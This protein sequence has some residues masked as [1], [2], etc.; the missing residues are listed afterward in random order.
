MAITTA[1]QLIEA[2]RNAT[3]GATIFLERGNY[4]V[5]VPLFVPDDVTLQGAGVMQVVDGLPVGFQAGTESTIKAGPGLRGNLVTLG[6]HSSLRRL[7]LHGASEALFEDDEGRG[8]NTVAVPSRGQHDMVSA[9][10]EE[11]ELINEIT[12]PSGPDGPAG[13][14]ILAYTRNPKRGAAPL[15]HVHAR[16]TLALTRSIVSPAPD[17]GKA[18]F[19]MNFASHGQVTINLTTNEIGGPL[20]VVGGMARP[21]AVD[22]A[23]TTVTSNGNHYS[24][25]G[26]DTGWQITGGSTPPL[27][28]SANADSNTANVNSTDDQIENFQNGIVAVGGRRLDLNHGTCARNT[29]NLSLTRMKPPTIPPSLDGADFQFVGALSLGSFP[30][31]DKNAVVVDVLAGTAPDPLVHIDVHGAGFGTGNQLVFKGTLAALQNLDFG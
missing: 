15:P 16:V 10:I 26:S 12:T 23:T 5:G 2:V 4:T 21:D 29:V 25:P 19:A 14:A 13:G 3:A 8:G 22:H 6:N 24:Q 1:E 30:T 7:V 18:V 31:G 28:S 11:C 9:T 17:G 20:D 27:L